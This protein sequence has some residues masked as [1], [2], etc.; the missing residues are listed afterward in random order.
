M[1]SG[2][3]VI[4]FVDRSFSINEKRARQ[5]MEF[6]LAHQTSTRFHFEI[7]AELLSDEML[8]FLATVPQD[9]FDFEIGIQ[10]TYPPT[11]E[12]IHR[13]TDWSHLR[14]RILNLQKVGNIHL[15]VDLIAG[16]PFESY[17]QFANSFNEVFQLQ[18]DVIQ[19]GF[20][21]ML[22]GS[23]L[24]E[25]ADDYQ[26]V[27][28]PHPPYE[29]LSNNVISFAELDRLHLVEDMLGRFYNSHH[30]EHTIEHLV[31]K[32]YHGN[33]FPC[34]EALAQAWLNNRYHLRQHNREAEYVFLLRF[35]EQYHP[36]CFD[37]LQELLKCDY[38]GSFPTGHLPDAL[39]SYNPDDD[40]DR[41]YNYLKDDDFIRNHFPQ[42]V[43]LSPRQRR[44]RVHLEWLKLDTENGA[45][46]SSARPTFFIYNTA[47]NK[48]EEL[49]Q[50]K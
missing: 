44:R 47:R 17:Q 18:A 11:L 37:W 39:E 49:W 27:F 19:L 1:K 23:P 41:L 50:L 10:S 24:G 34:F 36:S 26:Y 28:Q 14:E 48:L 7:N 4:K 38:L 13:H 29:V 45:Y 6:I 15:H 21:K 33:A 12:A 22:K 35:V 40:S 43:Q 42:L 25:Q 30:F 3:K 8:D 31:S 5:I 2:A 20:L 46:L 16:L 9:R 32:I